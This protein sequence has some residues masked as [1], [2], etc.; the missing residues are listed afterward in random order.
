MPPAARFRV[1]CPFCAE[2]VPKGEDGH[3]YLAGNPVPFRCG[4]LTPAGPA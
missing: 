2:G 3:H 1:G 4:A